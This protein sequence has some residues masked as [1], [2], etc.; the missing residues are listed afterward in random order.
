MRV[1]D[2]NWMQVE[3]YLKRDNRAVL[4]VGSTEQHGYLSLMVD[5][6]LSERVSADAAEPTGVPVFPTVTYGIP[7]YF[8]AFPGSISLHLKTYIS[9]IEDILNCMF[10]Q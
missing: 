2:M 8:R 10:E 5:C 1:K 3:E 7:P 6:I 4:P 9:L